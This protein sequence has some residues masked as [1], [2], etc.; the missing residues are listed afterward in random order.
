M[1]ETRR[2]SAER[3]NKRNQLV[4]AK[5]RP[6]HIINIPLGCR[7]TGDLV[8]PLAALLDGKLDVRPDNP[9][10]F[11]RE[12]VDGLDSNFLALAALAPLL[13]AIFRGFKT[14]DPSAMMKLKLKIAEDIRW[15]LRKD[16]IDVRWSQ[17]QRV[18]AGD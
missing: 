4:T 5:N 12:L 7:V 11:L 9:P 14:D 18:Q 17:K 13:D 6:Q 16:R 2:R 1:S 10:K 8:T 3:F 15:R